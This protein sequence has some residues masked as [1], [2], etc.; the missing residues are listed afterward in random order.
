MFLFTVP[1]ICIIAIGRDYIKPYITYKY[2]QRNVYC[3]TNLSNDL[4]FPIYLYECAI[5]IYFS[6]LR[7]VYFVIID[8][9]V[10]KTDIYGIIRQYTY[11]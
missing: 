3:R 4:Y 9:G 8:L 11:I 1:F 5:D 10:H 7:Y 6:F 2:F